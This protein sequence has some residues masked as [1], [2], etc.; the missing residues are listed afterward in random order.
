MF[1]VATGAFDL[2]ARIDVWP[3]ERCKIATN[4]EEVFEIF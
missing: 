1:L 3:H 4:L 2:I